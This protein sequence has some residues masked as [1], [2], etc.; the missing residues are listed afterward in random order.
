MSIASNE[1]NTTVDMLDGTQHV[2]TMKDGDVGTA[3]KQK[4][5]QILNAKL[6]TFRLLCKVFGDAKFRQ[7]GMNDTVPPNA[8]FKAFAANVDQTQEQAL[9][10]PT[11]SRQRRSKQHC[12]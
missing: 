8:V 5:A 9:A 7:I 12:R 4:V 6:S 1:F 3:L 2:I 11:R 10:W